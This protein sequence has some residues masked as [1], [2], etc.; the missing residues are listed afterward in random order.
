MRCVGF[1]G[2][3]SVATTAKGQDRHLR[4]AHPKISRKKVA[5]PFL[6]AQ[7][8]FTQGEK[9]EGMPGEPKPDSS[10]A[11]FF[12]VSVQESSVDHSVAIEKGGLL[13]EISSVLLTLK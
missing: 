11:P 13:H 10:I 8:C 2:S 7:T 6:S 1:C 9:T 12:M 4:I 5:S 3:R